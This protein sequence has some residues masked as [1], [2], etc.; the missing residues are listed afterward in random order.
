MRVAAVLLLV[1]T[2]QAWAQPDAGYPDDPLAEDR[3]RWSAV[4]QVTAFRNRPPMDWQLAEER[5]LGIEV[6]FPCQPVREVVSR[7]GYGLV[8][9]TCTHDGIGYLALLGRHHEP[10]SF[11]AEL[12]H[13]GSDL[14]MY[15]QLQ[16][17]GDQVVIE[18][19]AR[20]SY[21]G[22][23][24]R[25][26]VMR[27]PRFRLQKRTLARDGLTVQLQLSALLSNAS[28]PTAASRFFNAIR[29]PQAAAG[30]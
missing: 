25:E 28:A 7:A 30:D 16:A 23:S 4:G 26:I 18:P 1:F 22:F 17:D 20:I 15:Q 9:Y 8:R 21:H 2:Q 24:G 3:A 5:Y 29:L 19:L 10:A 11:N 14:G 13:A 6:S 12:F 27:S